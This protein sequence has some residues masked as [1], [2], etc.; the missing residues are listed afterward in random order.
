M[1]IVIYNVNRDLAAL[2]FGLSGKRRKIKYDM[3]YKSQDILIFK[4]FKKF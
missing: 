1:K 3:L 4:M 2:N